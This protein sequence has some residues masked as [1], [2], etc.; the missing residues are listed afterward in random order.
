MVD[1]DIALRQSA[2]LPGPLAAEDRRVQ[3]LAGSVAH[4]V[5]LLLG[6]P[7]ELP[8]LARSTHLSQ[9]R[10]HHALD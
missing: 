6:R 9:R 10:R 3:V 5:A 1:I 4:A 8:L 2:K 7:C